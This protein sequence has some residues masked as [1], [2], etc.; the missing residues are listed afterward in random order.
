[1]LAG[2]Y[3][4]VPVH[5]LEDSPVARL[6]GVDEGARCAREREAGEGLCASDHERGVPHWHWH[7]VEQSVGAVQ[8]QEA[9]QAR[10]LIMVSLP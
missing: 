10:A 3:A 7:G 8:A 6:F 4:A 2:Q 5:E 1:M 9:S